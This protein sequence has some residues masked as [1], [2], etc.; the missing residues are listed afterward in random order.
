MDLERLFKSTR[1][2]LFIVLT[3]SC[4]GS[5]FSLLS[6]LISGLFYPIYK[7]MFES[8]DLLE[9]LMKF[10]GETDSSLFEA[11]LEQYMAVP[12]IVYLLHALLFAMSLAGVIM[13]YKLRKNGAHLYA[14]AQLLAIIVTLLFLG[15]AGL[16]V[17]DLMMTLLFI[18]YYL[19]TFRRIGQLREAMD[20]SSSPDQEQPQP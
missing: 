2:G 3:L 12:R 4:I 16:N 5:A 1:R 14:V 13:M 6:N 17:G 11:A 15:R 7:A 19:V 18:I 9:M 20:A 8:G 10:S